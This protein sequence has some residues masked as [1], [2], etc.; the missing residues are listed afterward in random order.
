MNRP[1]FLTL[2]LTLACSSKFDDNRGGPDGPDSDADSDADADADTD[3]DADADADSDADVTDC[4][5]G[6]DPGEVATVDD[7]EYVPAPSGEPFSARI[8]WAMTHGAIDPTDGTIH[9]ATTFVDEPGL[10]SV[11]Q[12]P[13]VGQATDDDGDGQ[14]TNRDIPDIAVLMGD[15]FAAY[16]PGVYAY[17]SAIRL[18]SGD[19]S[20][21]HTTTL[22]DDFE[23][24]SYAPYLF[25]GLA[26]ADLDEDGLVEIVT[27]VRPESAL[28]P[29]T[30]LMCYAAVYEVDGTI[31]LEAVSDQAI[32]CESHAPAVADLEDDGQT[33]I[34][35]GNRVY[36]ASSLSVIWTGH[37]NGRL[38]L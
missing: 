22:W 13:V 32:S 14:I 7:C 12:A 17:W 1:L 19:G 29:A 27:I 36:D 21:V 10:D 38:A 34:V 3:A 26:M 23:G 4:A 37:W 2:I 25:A 20:S 31:N 16:D 33:E 6:P 5:D 11:F 18:I 28:R 9:P 8:E 15:E 35:L 30:G 24:T